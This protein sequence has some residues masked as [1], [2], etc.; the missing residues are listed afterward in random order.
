MCFFL[1]QFSTLG[2]QISTLRTIFFKKT[3]KNLL[4]YPEVFA[5]R[6]VKLFK[7]FLCKLRI[8][9]LKLRVYFEI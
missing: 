6:F 2:I 4:G 1:I 5:I 9:I 3:V 7:E 8:F